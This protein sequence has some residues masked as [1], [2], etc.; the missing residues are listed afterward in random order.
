MEKAEKII[1]AVEQ[2]A[3]MESG[4]KVLTEDLKDP[5]AD[6]LL[7]RSAKLAEYAVSETTGEFRDLILNVV[8]AAADLAIWCNNN[9]DLN[10]PR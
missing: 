5:D 2:L 6:R 10:S 8:K 9:W 4:E 1:E 3:Q 7:K